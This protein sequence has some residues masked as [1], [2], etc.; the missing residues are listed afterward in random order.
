MICLPHPP[1]LS[2]ELFRR[3]GPGSLTH[4]RGPGTQRRP[5][6]EPAIWD[7]VELQAA[8]GS[9]HAEPRG[10][11][12]SRAGGSKAMEEGAG[13]CILKS[14]PSSE[15]RAVG[16]ARGGSQESDLPV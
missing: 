14:R 6:P 8:P 11:L 2:G 4:L 12:P 7:T 15:G 3:G 10:P 5:G 13:A 16:G 1:F 9:T